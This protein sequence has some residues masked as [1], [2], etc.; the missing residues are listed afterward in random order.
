MKLAKPGNTSLFAALCISFGGIILLLTSFNFLSYTVF[1]DNIRGEII[2]NNSL[3]LHTTVTN[4]EKQFVQ[5]RSNLMAHLFKTEVQTV[6]DT[7]SRTVEYQTLL[8]IQLDLKGTLSSSRLYLENIVY[9]FKDKQL[10]IDKDGSRDL[11]T[12]FAK[13]YASD[14]YDAAFWEA[15]LPKA[16]SFQIYGGTAFEERTAFNITQHGTLLPVLAKKEYETQFGLIALL[17]GTAMYQD[18]HQRTDS[19]WFYIFDR[20][21]Q[22]IFASSSRSTD[23]DPSPVTLTGQGYVEQADAMYFYQ[24]APDTGYLYVDVIPIH[25]VTSQFKQ[26]NLVF[27]LI[28]L[29]SCV[30]SLIIALIIARKFQNPLQRILQTVEQLGQ[31]LAQQP[32][33]ITEFKLI[34]E[35]LHDL[36]RINHTIHRDLDTKNSLLQQYAYLNRLKMISANLTDIKMAIDSNRPYRLI[37][38]HLTLKEEALEGTELDPSRSYALITELIRM[39]FHSRCPDSLT[40][41]VEHDLILTILFDHPQQQDARDALEPLIELLRPETLYFQF[42]LGMSPSR[43]QA[44]QFSET[45]DKVHEYINQRQLDED[46]QVFRELKPITLPLLPTLAQEQELTANLHAGNEAICIPLVHRLI[47]Q[48]HKAGAPAHQIITLSKQIIEKA[49]KV[50]YAKH[51]TVPGYASPKQ[52]YEALKACRT[53]EDYKV[54]FEDFLSALA[55]AVRSKAKETEADYM[56]SFV[57]DYVERHYGEDISLD[58]LSQKLN[59]TNSYLSSYFKEKTGINLSEYTHTFRMGKAMEMLQS[60]DLKIQDIASL[61]GYLTVAPFNRAFKRHT[62]LT[63]TEYRRRHQSLE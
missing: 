8:K 22:P 15:E 18:L 38:V 19:G 57:K 46:I 2:K 24:Q 48:L 29:S 7:T 10:L 59:I 14:R 49:L 9:Y 60:T 31:P 16:Q 33:R 35:K 56:I 62:G 52:P 20:N 12:M 41:Q 63:P 43:T 40:F 17:N 26:L 44:E 54:F 21:G 5:L 37:L 23:H 11:E 47:E 30:L 3:N 39:H 58:L 42:A 28:L 61:V 53:V 45:Y 13:F 25:A 34:S 51:V 36:F 27:L 50:M 55:E 1:R 4:Y 6:S 32:S